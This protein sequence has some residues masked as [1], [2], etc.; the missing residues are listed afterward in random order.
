MPTT[1]NRRVIAVVLLVP[2]VVA[3]ALWAFAWPAARIAP[4]DL[5]IG[6]AG[7]QSAVAR[8]EQGLN[9]RKGAFD[10]HRYTDEK[11]ARRGIEDRV[12]YGAVVVAPEGPRLLTASAAGPAVAQLLQQ[13]VTAQAPAGTPVPVTDVVATPPGD[14]RGGTLAASV[15]PLAL[16]GVLT[17]AVVT[18][19]GLRGAR[20]AAALAG[21]AVAAGAVGAAM[22][23]SWL[24]AVTGDWWAV[25]GV[26]TLTVLAIGAG[27]AGLAAL[28]GRAGLGLGALLVVLL[29]N[30]FSGAGSAPELLPEPAGPIGQWLPPGAGVTLLRSVSFFDGAASGPALL[31]LSLWSALGM[32]AVALGSLRRP[33]TAPGARSAT[34]R[35]TPQPTPIG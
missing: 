18:L 15:L 12:V 11:A 31:T 9:Q 23:H 1:A 2:A 7:P 17:G 24:G 8:V 3:L 6:V 30:A 14:P 27:V 26:L 29:G 35:P 13:A 32:A 10:V 16:A 28:L 22:A 19:L 34:E 25:A 5:P 4:R 33:A 20:A 21:A